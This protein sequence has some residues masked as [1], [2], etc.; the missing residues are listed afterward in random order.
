MRRLRGSAGSQAPQSLPIRG[1]PDEVPEPRMRTFTRGVLANNVWKFARGGLPP[2][3]RRSSPRRLGQECGGVGDEGRLAGLAA[4]RHGREERRVGFDQQPVER[5]PRR[6]L[7][8][9][10]GVLERHDARDRDVEAQIQRDI[11]KSAARGEAMDDAGIGALPH[12]LAQDRGGIVLGI[13]G[14]DD[15]RQPGLARG[16]DMRAEARLLPVAVAMVVIIIEPALADADDA[17]MRGALDQLGGVDIGMLVGL[18][19]MD[20][21]RRPD[22]GLALGGGDARRPIRSR[23]SR[24]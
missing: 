6:G 18:V 12:F 5:Q 14:V 10:P 13:A 8:Q 21:D 23:A 24:C 16:G 11:G 22:I 3:P 2:V 4:M 7:L 1:T 19:R 15:D 20:A 9:I 17:R